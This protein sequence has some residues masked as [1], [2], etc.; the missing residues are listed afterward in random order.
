MTANENFYPR[1]FEYDFAVHLRHFQRYIQALAILGKTGADELWLDCASGSGYGT[2]LLSG[3]VQKIIGYDI[4]KDAVAYAREHYAHDDCVF[5]DEREPFS[6][7]RFDTIIS[8]ETIEHMERTDSVDFLKFLLGLLKK[9]GILVIT[10]PL[11]DVSNPNPS[12]V[13]HKY[14]YSYSEF[15]EILVE[16]GFAIDNYTATTVTFTDGETK[17]QAFFRCVIS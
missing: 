13:F 17:E 14:E 4:N 9:D 15:E 10:T 6:T 16:A 12:N 3:F 7:K 1:R 5:Y 2:N 8:I 11:V